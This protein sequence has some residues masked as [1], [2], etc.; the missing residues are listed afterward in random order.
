[1]FFIAKSVGVGGSEWDMLYKQ[2]S[3]AHVVFEGIPLF[4]YQV[5][6]LCYICINLVTLSSDSEWFVAI[7]IVSIVISLLTTIV[8]LMIIK[9]EA[10]VYNESFLMYLVL[11]VNGRKNWY[12]FSNQI[13]LA[14]QASLMDQQHLDTRILQSLK[15][16]SNEIDFSNRHNYYYQYQF[17]ERS[18]E[19]LLKDVLRLNKTSRSNNN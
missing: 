13:K 2:V 17:D 14:I 12:P 19:S 9:E 5:I 8:K 16:F 6:L 4:I 15:N 10:K 11:L 18:G 7:L 3:I 1:M